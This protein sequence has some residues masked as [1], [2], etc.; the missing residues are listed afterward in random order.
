VRCKYL[1]ARGG[2]CKRA[3][4]VESEY[5]LL[6]TVEDEE[7]DVSNEFINNLLENPHVKAGVGKVNSI[8]D[9][10]SAIVD[11]AARGEFPTF[12]AKAQAVPVGSPVAAARALMHFSAAEPLTVEIIKARRKHL[13]RIAHPD[14][15]ANG[16]NDAMVRINRATSIL[17][18]SLTS[19]PPK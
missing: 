10:F 12:K 11:S 9:K 8:L 15:T 4:A 2:T 14:A 7:A 18:E 16:S 1:G 3:P 5:C 19:R 17:L 6:H 13:A